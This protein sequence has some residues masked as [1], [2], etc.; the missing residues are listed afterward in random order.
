MT[1]D[2]FLLSQLKEWWDCIEHHGIIEGLYGV[3]G[4]LPADVQEHYPNYKT[5]PEGTTRLLQKD[6][7]DLFGRIK[8][9]LKAQ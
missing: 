7:K 1:K 3:N 8:Q 5:D 2:E 6:M 9:S 4:T